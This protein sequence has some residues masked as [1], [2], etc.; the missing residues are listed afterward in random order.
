HRNI[1]ITRDQWFKTPSHS[2]GNHQAQ[3]RYVTKLRFMMGLAQ[4]M[5]EMIGS[6]G[7]PPVQ[8]AMGE[9]AALVSIYEG[10]L[11]AHEASAPI[12]DGVLWPSVVTLYAAMAMQSEF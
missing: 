11:L 6:A 4:R 2:L 10:M 8:I 1:E 5:I 12:K 9:L 7:Q 3:V